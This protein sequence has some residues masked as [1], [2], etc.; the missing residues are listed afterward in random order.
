MGLLVL[1]RLIHRKT[2]LLL[3]RSAVLA[4]NV[5]LKYLLLYRLAQ[6]LVPHNHVS[7]CGSNR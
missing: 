2:C 3:V 7:R 1:G 5:H 4:V 6:L